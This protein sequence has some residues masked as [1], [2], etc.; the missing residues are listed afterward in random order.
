V[1]KHAGRYYSF[2]SGANWQTPRY[3]IDYV[4]AD[5]P[6]GPYSEGG[7]HARVLHGISDHVRGPGHHSTVFGPDGQTQYILYHAWDAQMNTRQMCLDKL[8][9]TA[10]G[11]RCIPTDTVQPA[12]SA[13]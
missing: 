12:P 11:P 4:V 5:N 2:Y 6:L 13:K 1:V 10:E 3:G 7:D 9:W 8:Q